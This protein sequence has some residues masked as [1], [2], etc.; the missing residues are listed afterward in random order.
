MGA[1]EDYL[2][3]ATLAEQHAK[4]ALTPQLRESFEHVA[5]RWRRLAEIARMMR[6]RPATRMSFHL[7]VVRNLRPPNQA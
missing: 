6:P 2:A 4:R 3:R 7:K 5:E 1:P